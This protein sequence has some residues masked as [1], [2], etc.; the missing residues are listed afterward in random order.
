MARL[1][2]LTE[3][4]LKT[5][6]YNEGLRLKVGP[7][8]YCVESRFASTRLGLQTLYG[9]FPLAD[10][11]GFADYHIALKPSNLLQRLRLKTRFLLDDQQ[12]FGSLHNRHAYAFLEW[13]MNWCISVCANE[14]L[15]LHSAVVAKNGVAMIMP[16][17][18]GAG[19][20]TLCAALALNGWRVLSDEHAM[21]HLG[22]ANVEP[23]YRP[24][25]L[26]NESIDVIRAYQP[27]V[28]MGPV[29]EETHKGVVAHLK[30]DMHP[31]SHEPGPVPARLMVF[32][33]YQ[34]GEKTQLRPRTRAEC[35]MFAAHHSFNYNVLSETGFE[36]MTALMDAVQCYELR[37]SN[38]DEAL[39][40][41]EDLG[42]Q[43]A[44]Q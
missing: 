23:L 12:P 17:L 25:S 18:P 11:S 3:K 1:G 38:L 32:P 42:A 26:K 27:D 13:G 41:L 43:A 28:V 2:D 29:T 6:L 22:T 19:K 34:R 4:Q 37:Y 10:P 5:A 21:I 15:K 31:A 14:Y 24:V 8:V 33:Q 39:R 20:S 44:A 35:F 9:D 7:Y 36:T 40:A 16:G 30:A